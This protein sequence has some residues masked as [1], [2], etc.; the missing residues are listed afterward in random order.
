MFWEIVGP[1]KRKEAEESRRKKKPVGY[2]VGRGLGGVLEGKE[3]ETL[4]D[5]FPS[6]DTES[7]DG[8]E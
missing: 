5:F 1:E 7:G 6:E 2:T 8:D 4:Y 3:V